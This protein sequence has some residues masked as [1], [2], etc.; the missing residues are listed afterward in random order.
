MIELIIN[1]KTVKGWHHP[2]QFGPYPLNEAEMSR[3]QLELEKA[4]LECKVEAAAFIYKD[5][6]QMYATVRSRMDPGKIPA[7]EMEKFNL[8]YALIRAKKGVKK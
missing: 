3:K 1:G 2:Y 6:Y 7:D 8:R 4:V 5:E